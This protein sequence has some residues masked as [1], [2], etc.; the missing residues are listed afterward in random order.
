METTSQKLT[1]WASLWLGENPKFV[2]FN[3]YLNKKWTKP[4]EIKKIP[5]N[6]IKRLSMVKDLISH[7]CE[8]SCVFWSDWF[9]SLIR[10]CL[11]LVYIFINNSVW[12]SKLSQEVEIISVHLLQYKFHW[13]WIWYKNIR[14]NLLPMVIELQSVRRWVSINFIN[15]SALMM[16][17]GFFQCFLLFWPSPRISQEVLL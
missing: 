2:C 6:T 9:S 1:P 16:D 10:G 17:I 5:I 14:I 8:T 15:L 7:F 12:L 11:I 4:I 3:F 13:V